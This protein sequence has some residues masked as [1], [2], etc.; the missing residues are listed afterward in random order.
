MVPEEI[1]QQIQKA[2]SVLKKGGVV[3]LPTE[4]AYGLAADATNQSAVDK[5]RQIKGRETQKSFPIIA[6]SREM[7]EQ[8]AGIPAVLEKLATH[9]WPGALTLVLPVMGGVLAPGVVRDGT[10][11]I[12]VS[13]HRVARAI[14][15]GLGCPIVSTS[16]NVAGQPTVY[17]VEDVQAQF[18]GREYQPDMYIDVGPLDP[19]VPPSTIVTVDDYGYPEVLRQGEINVLQ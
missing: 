7:V 3:V 19:S 14:S 9:H 16:A 18:N 6:A 15:Q 4:T 2:I 8:F 1:A 11:A 5:V 12:R 17:S 10:V 13:S